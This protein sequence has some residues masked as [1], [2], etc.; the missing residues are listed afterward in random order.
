MV[1]SHSFEDNKNEL[2]RFHPNKISFI[3]FFINIVT[4]HH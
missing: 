3:S 4:Y 1:V 2:N